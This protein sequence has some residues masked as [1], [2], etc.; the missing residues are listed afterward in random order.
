[1][2]CG[3]GSI[4]IVVGSACDHFAE[5]RL[6]LAS[7][8]IGSLPDSELRIMPI[9]PKR[10][11]G[12]LKIGVNVDDHSQDVVPI[13]RLE[14]TGARLLGT[15]VVVAEGLLATALHT[16]GAD[17][18]NVVVIPPRHDNIDVYQDPSDRRVST[19]PVKLVGADPFRDL[20]L[21][22]LPPEVRYQAHISIGGTD[23]IPTGAA[24]TAWG[25][26]HANNGRMVLTVQRSHI[27]AR[28]ML[29]NS[30]IKSKHIIL[31]TQTTRGQS[32]SPVFA[33]ET[34]RLVAIIV[35]SYA[36]GAGSGIRLGDIDP[37]TLHQTTHAVSAEYIGEMLS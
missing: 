34:G 6:R 20:C 27:G 22:Q 23:E 10:A 2:G 36:P 15:G 24:V 35:G 28:V 33:I 21:I 4:A 25:F 29:E 14:P 13:A 12:A 3:D 16:I 17:D 8:R 7:V 9:V 18:R 19:V 30:T 11:K 32:G 26:P 5:F 37:F 31:N 1:M